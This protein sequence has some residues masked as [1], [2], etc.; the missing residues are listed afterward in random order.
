MCGFIRRL[1]V[2]AAACWAS[3]LLLCFISGIAEGHHASLTDWVRQVFVLVVFLWG[4][5]TL[6]V[7][8]PFMVLGWAVKPLEE[9]GVNAI[10]VRHLFDR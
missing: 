8:G 4:V 2:F 7:G 1:A 5:P 10:E 3:V 9:T 6:L